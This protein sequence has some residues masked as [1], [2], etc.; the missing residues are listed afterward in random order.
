MLFFSPYSSI[1][2]FNHKSA[3]GGFTYLTFCCLTRKESF[4]GSYLPINQLLAP[5]LTKRNDNKFMD[6]IARTW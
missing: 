4:C 5:H 2:H 1:K 6:I 3:R